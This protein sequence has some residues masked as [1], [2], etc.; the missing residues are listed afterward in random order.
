MFLV[1]LKRPQEIFVFF[2]ILFQDFDGAEKV[3]STLPLLK[4]VK[5]A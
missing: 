5:P 1:A 4:E 2:P 3:S